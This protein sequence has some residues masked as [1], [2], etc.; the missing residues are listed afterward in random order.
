MDNDFE[1]FYPST[2]NKDLFEN[3]YQEYEIINLSDISLIENN[4]LFKLFSAKINNGEHYYKLGR[5]NLLVE[6]TVEDEDDI[7]MNPTFIPKT[8]KKNNPSRDIEKLYIKTKSKEDITH[9]NNT[10]SNITQQKIFQTNNC[11]QNN[12]QTNNSQQ[13]IIEQ[14]SQFKEQNV[15]LL[16]F[17]IVKN[18]ETDISNLISSIY[19]ANQIIQDNIDFNYFYLKR[20]GYC[21]NV[22]N[23]SIY[24]IYLD[25]GNKLIDLKKI[26]SKIENPKMIILMY[27]QLFLEFYLKNYDKGLNLLLLHPH[28]IFQSKICG[29]QLIDFMFAEL[30]KKLRFDVNTFPLANLFGIFDLELLNPEI[31]ETD[32]KIIRNV[33][34]IILMTI[35]LAFLFSIDES[36]IDLEEYSIRNNYSNL[37]YKFRLDY[38]TKNSSFSRFLDCIYDEKVKLFISKVLNLNYK[39]IVSIYKFKELFNDL[40]IKDN[41]KKFSCITNDC[42]LKLAQRMNFVCNHFLCNECYKKH[43]NCDKVKHNLIYETN[44]INVFSE[45]INEVIINKQLKFEITPHKFFHYYNENAKKNFLKIEIQQEQMR[46]YTTM[47]D[48]KLN[49]MINF[50]DKLLKSSEKNKRDSVKRLMKSVDEEI[51]LIIEKYEKKQ[52][53]TLKS[54]F[55]TIKSREKDKKNKIKLIENPLALKMI[56]M[57]KRELLKENYKSKQIGITDKHLNENYLHKSFVFKNYYTIY[58]NFIEKIKETKKLLSISTSSKNQFIEVSKYEDDYFN[59]LGSKFNIEFRNISFQY[60]EEIYKYYCKSE[61]YDSIDNN[62]LDVIHIK[63]NKLLVSLDWNRNMLY[64]YNKKDNADVRLKLEF[65]DNYGPEPKII[66]RNCKWLNL[67]LKMFVTGGVYK[68]DK[69]IRDYYSKKAFYVYFFSKSDIPDQ[70]Y[71]EVVRDMEYERDQHCL[72]HINSLYIAAIGGSKTLVCELYNIL[73]NT[74][75]NFEDE[76]PFL[77]LNPSGTLID[78]TNLYIFFGQSI[79]KNKNIV[80]F[81]FNSQILKYTFF[82]THKKW[83]V[84]NI[85][86]NESMVLFDFSIINYE[87]KLFLIGGKITIENVAEKCSNLIW[88]YDIENNKIERS[89]YRL[90]KPASFLESNFVKTG[91]NE[92]ALYSMDFHLVKLKI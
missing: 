16:E 49:N 53:L 71:V 33:S 64:I 35:F 20:L 86:N 40:L 59:Y 32:K 69:E 88:E 72:V 61:L 19:G 66:L 83:E 80:E 48:E 82:S 90:P 44:I 13:N 2:S 17:S 91:N 54:E 28:F 31:Y 60:E 52:K 81:E 58:S 12:F 73:E 50:I 67:G 23:N 63:E 38:I 25:N 22:K 45:K 79:T 65:P 5:A 30:F 78:N 1:T 46:R 87:D 27:F 62:M 43:I 15:F 51:K 92:F 24:L 85:S 21:R 8:L 7:R 29:F 39:N 75:Q 47:I 41:L 3:L 37:V 68:K 77:L 26:Y 6:H 18:D 9:L 84:I 70:R 14:S 36:K 10:P 42:E 57:Q 89:N 55:Q 11:Q 4:S 76:L 74:W 34:D 56:D